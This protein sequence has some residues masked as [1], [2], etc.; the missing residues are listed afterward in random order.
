[1]GWL[2]GKLSRLTTSQSGELS[3]AI[4]LWVS[5]MSTSES[6]SVKR[7]TVRCIGPISV[8]LYVNWRLAEG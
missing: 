3:L 7:H 2:I 1:M 6:S 8:V 5:T 4:S